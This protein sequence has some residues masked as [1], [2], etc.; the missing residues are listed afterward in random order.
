M[1]DWLAL[2]Q[3]FESMRVEMDAFYL[4]RGIHAHD[5]ARHAEIAGLC[6]GLRVLDVGCGTGDLL[7][8][9]QQAHPEWKLHGTDISAVALDLARRRG[10]KADLH[11]MA[12][13]PAKRF[14]TVVL[15]QVLEHL[16]AAVG[17]WLL[18]EV[19]RV[20]SRMIVSV[21]NGGAVKSRHHIRTFTTATLLGMLDDY[22]RVELH[23]WSGV[24][25]R[26]IAV[27]TR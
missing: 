8:I 25:K 14:N 24:K 15:S 9:L 19:M 22:G 1:G 26:L 2:P 18:D 6:K 17:Q 23:N 13:I 3:V 10:V 16:D 27:V 12:T 21:P 4:V 5:D 20:T 11:C 7:L